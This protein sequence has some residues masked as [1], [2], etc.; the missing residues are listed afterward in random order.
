MSS[1]IMFAGGIAL[2]VFSILAL[3]LIMSVVLMREVPKGFVY[4]LLRKGKH[5]SNLDAG[6]YFLL[7]FVDKI[8]VKVD[9]QDKETQ[10]E[11][12]VSYSKEG[13]PVQYLPIVNYHVSDPLLFG[14]A[15]N[16]QMNEFEAILGSTLNLVMQKLTAKMILTSRTAFYSILGDEINQELHAWGLSLNSIKLAEM[17]IPESI[18]SQLKGNKSVAIEEIGEL[19]RSSSVNEIE[20]ATMNEQSFESLLTDSADKNQENKNLIKEISELEANSVSGETDRA[21]EAKKTFVS[22]SG[23]TY[24]L[25]DND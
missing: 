11:R 23:F 21:V 9:I 18:I 15:A 16:F 5:H 3:F 24:S 6:T 13:I 25:K 10:F 8:G 14:Q 4:M 17:S 19:S 12:H 22:H 2:G 20:W 7:P 1:E